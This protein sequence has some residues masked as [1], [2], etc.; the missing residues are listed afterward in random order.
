MFLKFL[1]CT[2]G[3]KLLDKDTINIRI[4]KYMQT[5]GTLIKHQSFITREGGGVAGGGTK[6]HFYLRKMSR[7]FCTIKSL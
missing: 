6:E 4:N 1:E 5:S 2:Q 7:A 3:G